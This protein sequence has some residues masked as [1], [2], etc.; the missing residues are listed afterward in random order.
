MRRRFGS[1]NC[2]IL[3]KDISNLILF[4]RDNLQIDT[5][6]LEMLPLFGKPYHARRN[7]RVC[8]PSVKNHD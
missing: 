5:V 2:Q 6:L 4:E 3:K 8:E 7:Q 1:L